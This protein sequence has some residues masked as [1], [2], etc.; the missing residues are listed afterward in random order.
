MPAKEPTKKKR[1][2]SKKKTEAIKETDAVPFTARLMAYYRAQE[3]NN[4]SPLIDDPFAEQL[5]GD[6]TEYV[7]KHSV[8]RGDYPVVRSYYI[9]TRFLAPWCKSQAESQIVLLG[10]GL[11]TRA[12]R[13][14]PLEENE[15]TIFEIDLRVVNKYKERLLK[16]ETPRCRL[17][18]LSADL[19]KRRWVSELKK[20]GFSKDVPTF[21]VLEG[22]VYYMEQEDVIT[23]LKEAAKMSPLGSLIFADVCVPGLADAMYGPL[24]MHF[25][26]GLQE[27][28][29]PDFFAASGW[30][31]ACSFADDHDQG[32]DVG[33]RGLIF[34][35]GAR[36]ESLADLTTTKAKKIQPEESTLSI[37]DPEL[38]TFSL[39]TAQE[40]IPQ[41]EHVVNTFK[42]NPKEGLTAYLDFVEE[43]KP[44]MM[45]IIK[46]FQDV[47][48]IGRISP[49]LL[50]DP[51]SMDL[52]TL[53]R[54]PDEVEAHVS[55]FLKAILMLVYCG[56][57]GLEGS[58]F[59]GTPVHKEALKQEGV[60]DI[61][62]V[63]IIAR[64]V[65]EEI[66]KE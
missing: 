43:V 48:S 18:R 63:S 57:K 3:R 14:K 32:R 62:S 38:Q 31:V 54:A 24:M 44:S 60:T 42:N 28:E 52:L 66:T 6:M 39:Q 46:G 53:R 8:G 37:T 65:K 10:A 36:K 5:A 59:S 40:V 9:E 56:A 15:H 45:K 26:W 41:I 16:D 51:L 20:K 4:Q 2:R 61:S 22:L 19:S 13:F 12:Y 11:D 29:I 49:R 34:V 58:Q 35:Q 30:N 27:D 50:R 21:W 25:K 23:L 7:S 55:G 47:T 64:T 33:Q 1:K 17:V